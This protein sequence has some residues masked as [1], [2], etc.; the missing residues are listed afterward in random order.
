MWVP[1]DLMA[2]LYD[3]FFSLPAMV[4]ICVLKCFQDGWTPLLCASDKGHTATMETL[5]TARADANKSD[6]VSRVLLCPVMLHLNWWCLHDIQHLP[7]QHMH[8]L[9]AWSV[10]IRVSDWICLKICQF[11]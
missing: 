6:T 11:C 1:V 5:L 10:L 4:Q 9:A 3:D 8:I 2:M 7:S